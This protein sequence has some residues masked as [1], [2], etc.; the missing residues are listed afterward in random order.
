MQVLNMKNILFVFLMIPVLFVALSCDN[1]GVQTKVNAGVAGVAGV[2]VSDVEVFPYSI[3][4]SDGNEVVFDGP[5]ERIIAIDSSAVEILFSLGQE[6]RLVGT[7]DF[8]SYPPEVAE[9]PRIGDA[10]NLNLESIVDL[11]PDLVFVFSKGFLPD[12]SRAGLKVLYLDSLNTS[13]RDIPQNIRM[14]G[15]IT[16]N[17]KRAEIEASKIEIRI[18]QIQE[19]VSTRT[20][21]PS[22]FLDDGD[23]WTPGP[24]TMIGEALDFLNLQNIAYDISGYEQLSPEI[25]VDRDPQIIVAM[26]GNTISDIPS[27]KNISAVKNGKIFVPKSDSL[28]IAGP[29][30]IDAIEELYLWIYSNDVW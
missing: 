3:L 24:D 23:F 16:G 25:I 9:I 14:W 12:L 15:H 30:F 17:T 29:R 6:H 28:A 18:S 27:F 19:I 10:F 26:T 20:V 1:Q 8:V 5:P 7:H 13:F 11:D 4:D 22:I 2:V 21:G